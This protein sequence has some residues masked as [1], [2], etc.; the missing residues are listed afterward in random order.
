M[1]QNLLLTVFLRKKMAKRDRIIE[2]LTKKLKKTEEKLKEKG[3][4]IKQIKSAMRIK[5][6]IFEETLK[7]YVTRMQKMIEK[8]QIKPNSIHIEEK[9]TEENS[10]KMK[11]SV[12]EHNKN[13]SRDAERNEQEK[14]ETGKDYKK[15]FI[16]QIGLKTITKIKKKI[17]SVEM[18]ELRI[19][20]II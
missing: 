18:K 2:E 7:D 3:E 5:D 6:T 16:I 14:I 9:E 13:V 10:I 12:I 1:K 4:E 19:Q 20:G 11:V 15:Y 8:E 17:K